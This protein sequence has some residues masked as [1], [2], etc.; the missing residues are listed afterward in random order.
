MPRLDYEYIKNYKVLQSC[1][2]KLKISKHI[3]VDKLV[4]GKYQDNLEFMQWFKSFYDSKGGAAEDYNAVE[5]RSRSRNAPKGVSSSASTSR[6]GTS[7]STARSSTRT[8][9]RKA[10]IKETTKENKVRANAP[11]K[12]TTTGSSTKQSSAKLREANEKLVRQVGT[13]K[14]EIQSLRAAAT[15][16]AKEAENETEIKMALDGLERERDFYFKK[17]RDI[18]VRSR[19]SSCCE[20]ASVLY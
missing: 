13:L 19:L 11:V 4:R 16:K 15:E 12:K 5:S 20:K 7:R 14:M 8:T 9:T 10:A 2:N 18:E 3:P 17:L 1:F 6:T